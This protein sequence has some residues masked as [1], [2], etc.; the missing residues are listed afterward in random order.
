MIFVVGCP[1]SGTSL[2]RDL[3][4]SHPR[5]TFLPETRFIP[6][7]YRAYG[8][9]T[10]DADARRL[11]R[12]ILQMPWVRR[13]NPDL[14]PDDFVGYRSYRDVVEHFFHEWARQEGKP[15]WGDKTPAY[16]A[17][18]P[19][20]AGLFPEARFL[21]LIR[22]GRDVALSMIRAPFGPANFYRAAIVWKS[23][24]EAGRRGAETL[25][26]G[27]YKEVF[28]ESLL[29]QPETS[30][31]AIC[32]FLDEPFDDAMLRPNRLRRDGTGVSP[33]DASSDS[34]VTGNILKWKRLARPEDVGV[35]ETVAADLLEELGY[36][37]TGTG[38]SL[39]ATRRLSWE[40]Q[41]RVK[42]SLDLVRARH[43]LRDYLLLRRSRVRARLRS[44]GLAR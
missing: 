34:I 30:L 3:L 37:T 31:R 20:L 38:R 8:D 5:L 21:H 1:R 11:A 43:R 10:S 12:A 32:G 4:R 7:F 28:Y 40:I 13:W 26:S 23:S 17:E 9:P 22:D 33:P 14:E 15:R 36:E 2:L 6:S 35:F 29:A 18:I 16:V 41:D 24:I 27:M 25:P 44:M 39:P 19:T 42:R